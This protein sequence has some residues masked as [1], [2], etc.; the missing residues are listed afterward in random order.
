MY[1]YAFLISFF[2]GTAISCSDDEADAGYLSG[3]FRLDIATVRI[4]NT[5]P[6]LALDSKDTL[7]AT[8]ISDFSFTQKDG[9]RVLVNHSPDEGSGIVIHSVS[10]ILT[11]RIFTAKLDT[12]PSDP[13]KIQSV[14]TGGGYLNVIL[15]MNY[16][17]KKHIFGLYRSAESPNDLYL[18]H[19]KQGDSEGYPVRVYMSFYLN[20][21]QKSSNDSTSF[22]V[23]IPTSSGDENY[24]FV[25]L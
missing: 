7:R 17:S 16:Y 5:T 15:Y 1:F 3:K 19:D 13:V 2:S 6:V 18:S 23:T 10:D 9:Q 14:W 24:D 11:S 4:E 22:S 25:F 21:L 20:G 8:S 12:L